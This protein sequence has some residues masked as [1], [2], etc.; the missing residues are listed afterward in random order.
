MQL[1][2]GPILVPLLHAVSASPLS[3]SPGTGG[4]WIVQTQDDTQVCTEVKW[5]KDVFCILTGYIDAK[6]FINLHSYCIT[7][8]IYST[9]QVP[10]LCWHDF[11]FS[12]TGCY[13]LHHSVARWMLWMRWVHGYSPMQI[14]CTTVEVHNWYIVTLFSDQQD[15][16]YG[17]LPPSLPASRWRPTPGRQTGSESIQ[18]PQI[19]FWQLTS[20]SVCPTIH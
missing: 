4:H 3:S 6:V 1:C 14:V 2:C 13:R 11:T 15:C 19:S 16:S 5:D 12:P 9:W 18:C 20:L 17:D 7:L 8:F 10:P